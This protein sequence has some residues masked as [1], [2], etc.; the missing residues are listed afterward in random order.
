MDRY[1]MSFFKPAFLNQQPEYTKSNGK[2]RRGA[3][4]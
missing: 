3:I 1:L 2:K 4:L